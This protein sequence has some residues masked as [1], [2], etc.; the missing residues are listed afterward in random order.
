MALITYIFNINQIAPFFAAYLYKDIVMHCNIGEL[1][2]LLFSYKYRN[3][4]GNII[5][6]IF[7]SFIQ[8]IAWWILLELMKIDINIILIILLEYL[9]YFVINL[10]KGFGLIAVSIIYQ[11]TM[12][13]SLILAIIFS[14]G[15]F[16]TYLLIRLIFIIILCGFIFIKSYLNFKTFLLKKVNFGKLKEQIYEGVKLQAREIYSLGILTTP[17]FI[18]M[19]LYSSDYFVKYMLSM[20]IVQAISSLMQAFYQD[21]IY[22]KLNNIKS[23]TV[24]YTSMKSDLGICILVIFTAGF[25]ANAWIV[26]GWP[27]LSIESFGFLLIV[28]YSVPFLIPKF[29]IEIKV[30]RLNIFSFVVAVNLFLALIDSIIGKNIITQIFLIL[31]FFLI[32]SGYNKSLSR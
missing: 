18:A 28:F 14:N 19:N 5:V 2:A 7:I 1:Q 26:K 24:T 4:A 3:Y 8:I 32:M 29:F 9:Y 16:D 20:S 15:N 11:M 21:V 22:K 10:Y 17:K 30:K 25:L 12:A 13:F 23:Y 27:T 31:M 6:L